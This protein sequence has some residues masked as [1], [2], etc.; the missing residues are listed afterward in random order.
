[1]VEEVKIRIELELQEAETDI[2]EIEERVEKIDEAR[3]KAKEEREQE[4]REAAG[5]GE[6]QAITRPRFAA[7]TFGL[8]SAVAT[9]GVAG[10]TSFF[11]SQALSKLPFISQGKC[12]A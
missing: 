8:L 6:P 9:G 12:T 5:A 10:V 1:M 2:E 7:P 11:V 4:R 3:K